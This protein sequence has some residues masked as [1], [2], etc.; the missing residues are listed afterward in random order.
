MSITEFISLDLDTQQRYLDQ[1]GVLQ[2]YIDSPNRIY[3]YQLSDF[4]AESHFVY[5]PEYKVIKIEAF[6][7][8]ERLQPFL[9]QI[10]ISLYV[11][12]PGIRKSH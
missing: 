8:M 6:Y 1:F 2:G 3:L 11:T 9:D 7:D 10:D 12:H 4:Y 5:K